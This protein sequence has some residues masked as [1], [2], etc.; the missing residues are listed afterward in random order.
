MHWAYLG[1][2]IVAEVTG[3][4]ALKQSIGFSRPAF[5]V[6]SVASFAMALF[7]LSLALGAIP[8]G[9]A[10]AIWAGIGIVLASLLGLVAFRQTVD[11]AAIVGIGLIVCGVV[12]INTLSRS[13]TH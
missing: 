8:L 4:A 2:A 1:L 13:T 5:A 12:V 7:F 11:V 6:L 9:I 10:Y 3:T